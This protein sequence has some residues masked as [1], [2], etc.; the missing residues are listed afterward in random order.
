MSL[1]WEFTRTDLADA[2]KEQYPPT[3]DGVMNAVTYT[4]IMS[5][6]LVG[7]GELTEKTIPEF[8]VQIN[9]YES[10]HDAFVRNGH[11]SPRPITLD[12]LRAHIG[13]KTNVFPMEARTKWVARA[14]TKGSAFADRV[15]DAERVLAV[16]DASV[17]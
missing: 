14:I 15:R 8:W 4:L 3:A 13:L 5:T 16:S 17:G 12:D 9:I 6:M 2:R 11:G 1:N 7:I 10:L